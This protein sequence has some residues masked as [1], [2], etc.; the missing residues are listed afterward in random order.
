MSAA[1]ADAVRQY[2]TQLAPVHGQVQLVAA[3]VDQVLVYPERVH[4]QAVNG[5]A[6]ASMSRV[7]GALHTPAC[8]IAMPSTKSKTGAAAHLV[9]LEVRVPPGVRVAE[10]RLAPVDRHRLACGDARVTH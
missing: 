7:S 6:S 5:L 4:L 2:C 9:C 10:V 3:E 1:F 8:M